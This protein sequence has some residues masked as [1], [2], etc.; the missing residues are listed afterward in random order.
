[1]LGAAQLV[2]ASIGCRYF[3]HCFRD[4]SKARRRQGEREVNYTAFARHMT[5]KELMPSVVMY[6]SSIVIGGRGE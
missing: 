4:K 6:L 1:M 3:E 5:K 2:V